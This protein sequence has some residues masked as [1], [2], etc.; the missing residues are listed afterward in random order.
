MTWNILAKK[1]SCMTGITNHWTGLLDW[2]SGLHDI[3][4]V[5]SY[6]IDRS[7][8]LLIVLPRVL[9][10]IINSWHCSI[11]SYSSFS[12]GLKFP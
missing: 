9:L 6:E 2:N 7:W 11:A 3:F 1:S 5:F 4:F 8:F 10:T 12:S